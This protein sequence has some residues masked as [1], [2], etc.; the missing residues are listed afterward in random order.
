MRNNK[1]MDRSSGLP[2]KLARPAQRALSNAGITTLKQLS[3]FSEKEITELHGIGNH[4]MA[5]IKKALI[6][7]GISF[8][9][10][11]KLKK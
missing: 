8:S 1:A 3:T 7:N 4:A 10:D 2:V 11:K 6:E 9:K 5:A